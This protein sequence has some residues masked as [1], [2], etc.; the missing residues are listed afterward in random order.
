[1]FE[2]TTVWRLYGASPV[3]RAFI[4]FPFG[5]ISGATSLRV[6]HMSK[7]LAYASSKRVLCKHVAN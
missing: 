2:E 3:Q 1:M 6:S 4:A 5:S 7:R